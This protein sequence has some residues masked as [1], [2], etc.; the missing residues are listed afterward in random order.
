MAV[1]PAAPHLRPEL[2]RLATTYKAA[3]IEKK[4][5]RDGVTGLCNEIDAGVAARIRTAKDLGLT[6]AQI[7]EATGMQQSN[8]S[9]LL[10]MYA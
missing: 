4:A 5:L 3:Q 1:R 2:D 7:A 8:L 6:N 9:L 10:R